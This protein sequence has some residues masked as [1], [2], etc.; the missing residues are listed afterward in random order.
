MLVCSACLS[1]TSLQ[2]L[3][4][5]CV[6]SMPHFQTGGVWQKHYSRYWTAYAARCSQRERMTAGQENR[7]DLPLPEEKLQQ[8]TPLVP[9]KVL[10]I[11]RCAAPLWHALP[12]V[13]PQD[14]CSP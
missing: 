6:G 13:P 1:L 7:K 2:Q 11:C 5:C 8:Y 10:Y 3:N 4:Q 14:P 9:G 12:S